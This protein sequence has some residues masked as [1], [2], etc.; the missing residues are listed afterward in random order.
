MSTMQVEKQNYIS[1]FFNDRKTILRLLFIVLS[2][3]LTISASFAGTKEQLKL[4]CEY[5]D[6][7]KKGHSRC[8]FVNIGKKVKITPDGEFSKI[9]KEIIRGCDPEDCRPAM[10]KH[11]GVL[12][13]EGWLVDLN[14]DGDKEVIVFPTGD[15]RGAS[16]NGDILIFQRERTKKLPKWRFR[17]Y[18]TGSTLH[19][20]THKTNNYYDLI[21]IWHMGASSG[22]FYQ[23]KMNRKTGTYELTKSK[24][25]SCKIQ[26]TAACF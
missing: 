15:L 23:Y 12:P 6:S 25:Y 22:Y 8:S 1:R 3:F 26:S 21:F 24:E 18:M 5:F 7:L 20:D 10:Q 16:G 11:N 2:I 14:G 4:T 9:Y 19:V 13:C 17:G